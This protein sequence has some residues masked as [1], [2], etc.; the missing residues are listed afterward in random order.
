MWF[1]LL[2]ILKTTVGNPSKLKWWLGAYGGLKEGGPTHAW[3]EA[4][5]CCDV[6][7]ERGRDCDLYW[8]PLCPVPQPLWSLICQPLEGCGW[9]ASSGAKPENKAPLS[10][11]LRLL[12]P[13]IVEGGGSLV[14]FGNFLS[15]LLW[16]SDQLWRSLAQLLVSAA[17]LHWETWPR[18]AVWGL[19]SAWGQ[20]SPHIV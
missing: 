9:R 2:T 4:R 11:P 15:F 18:W 14:F 13:Q 20:F 16:M 1:K 12:F 6:E 10:V 5:L 7:D 8:F 19:P 3:C 17:A